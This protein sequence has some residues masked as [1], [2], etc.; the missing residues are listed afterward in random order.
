MKGFLTALSI[1]EALYVKLCGVHFELGCYASDGCAVQQSKVLSASHTQ[2]MYIKG[3]DEQLLC[4]PMAV[5]IYHIQKMY[6]V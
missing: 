6:F 1:I 4:S 3:E 5:N 2:N